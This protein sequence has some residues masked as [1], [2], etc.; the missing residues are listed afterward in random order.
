VVLLFAL[1]LII[2]VISIVIVVLVE[3]GV[4]LLSLGEVGDEVG[5]VTA[6]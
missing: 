5:G 6:L 4:E 1:T 3:G 2:G